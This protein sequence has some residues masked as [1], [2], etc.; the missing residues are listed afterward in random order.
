FYFF[1]FQ[2]EDG[3]RDRNVTGVQTCALPIW[4]SVTMNTRRLTMDVPGRR[5][6]QEWSIRHG[7]RPERVDRGVSDAAR[8]LMRSHLRDLPRRRAHSEGVARAMNNLYASAHPTVRDEAVAAGL[9]HDI[10]YGTVR[11]GLHRLDGP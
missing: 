7:D 10:G 8:A 2:A 5:T 4:G 11:T 1:F 9:V 6:G 3:I